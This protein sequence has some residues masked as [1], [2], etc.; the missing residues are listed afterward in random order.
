[1]PLGGLSRQELLLGAAN[2]LLY[3]RFYT[4][5]YG[6]MIALGL[7]SLVTAFVE[8]C[9]S[10][11]FILLESTLCICM[12]FEIITRAIATQW[13]FFGSLWNYADIVIVLFCGL[14]LVLL[15]RGCSAS[16]NSE[17]LVNTVLLVVRNAAQIF[18][19][20]ATL[21]KNHR[22]I[23]ARGMDLDL[24]GQ[25]GYLDLINDVDAMLAEPA[26]YIHD[27]QNNNAE[28]RLSIDSFAEDIASDS[29]SSATSVRSNSER[30]T[31]RRR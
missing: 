1:M 17:E 20:L 12:L 10:L 7:V 26:D 22:Q 21:R 11:F 27:A 4:Y 3:S 31:G 24:D 2:R 6:L 19:L 14:T 15:S 23:D 18:R 25:S 5:Y 30:L 29:R 13:G 9:P 28:F 8:S 16:S